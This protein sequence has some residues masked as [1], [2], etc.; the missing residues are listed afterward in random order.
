M[1]MTIKFCE[2]CGKTSMYAERK[3][4]LIMCTACAMALD[5]AKAAKEKNY[6]LFN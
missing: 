5:Y 2:N 1:K 6:S 3:G 4:N